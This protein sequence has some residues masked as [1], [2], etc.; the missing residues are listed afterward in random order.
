MLVFN[1]IIYLLNILKNGC[2]QFVTFEDWTL[3]NQTL[4]EILLLASFNFKNI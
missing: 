3:K 1:M 4:S 2:F